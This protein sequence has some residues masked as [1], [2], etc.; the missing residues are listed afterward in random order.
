MPTNDLLELARRSS[1]TLFIAQCPH[2][3]L[4][5]S[6][7]LT[8]PPRQ[9]AQTLVGL[10]SH[11]AQVPWTDPTIVR[12]TATPHTQPAIASAMLV[13]AVRKT[14]AIFP[15]MITVG[16]TLNNDV[17]LDDNSISK[18][19][20]FFQPLS[21]NRRFLLFDAGST[22]GTF[23]DDRLLPREGAP[24]NLTAGARIRFGALSFT[25]MESGTCWDFIRNL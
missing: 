25:L 5:G 3:V 8:Q 24:A 12:S 15:N 2:L 16:R 18:F 14:Q 19:H 11:P 21:E 22:N 4:V 13:M 17:C 9:S 1:R 6:N 7:N 23:V 10:S 20:A